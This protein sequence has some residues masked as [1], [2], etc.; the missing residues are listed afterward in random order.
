MQPTPQQ[1]EQYENWL[2]H[3]T[4]QLFR[5][6]LRRQVQLLQDSWADAQF[7]HESSDATAQLNAKA[8]GKVSAIRDIL[9]LEPEDIFN[10]P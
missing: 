6:A 9:S 8:L 1:L 10:Q 3:P 2:S 7:T 4:T 5:Q